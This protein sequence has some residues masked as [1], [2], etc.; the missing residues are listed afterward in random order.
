MNKNQ[1]INSIFYPRKS[2]IPQ[3]SNDQLIETDD[4]NQTLIKRTGGD[5]ED[6]G[7]YIQVD[8]ETN[9]GTVLRDDTTIMENIYQAMGFGSARTKRAREAE[10]MSRFYET[11][12][13]KKQRAM[14]AQLTNAYR[15]IIM[16]NKKN[17]SAL[18]LKGQQKINELVTLRLDELTPEM[19][20]E[21]IERIIQKHLGWLVVWGGVFGGLIGLI[22]SFVI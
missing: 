1:I 2:N 13:Q 17:D 4:G 6:L 14:N 18:S 11:R 8:L 16:G 15:D 10:Y 22:T 21:I 7:S 3:D 19:V 12:N 9:Y 20:K 5:V